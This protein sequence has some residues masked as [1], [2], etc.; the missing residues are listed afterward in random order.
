MKKYSKVLDQVIYIDEKTM[1]TTT[2]DGCQYNR[3]ELNLLK[4][5]TDEFKIAAHKVKKMFKGVIL[6]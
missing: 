3:D 6:K 2:A 5:N 4:K 1:Y